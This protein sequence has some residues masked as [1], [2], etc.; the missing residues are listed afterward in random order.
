MSVLALQIRKRN[1]VQMG[2]SPVDAISKVIDRKSVWP[3]DVILPREDSCKV[4][5]IHAHFGDVRLQ[6]PRGKVQVTDSRVHNDRSRIHH[7]T[8][9][10]LPSRS[11]QFGHVQILRVSVQPVQLPAHPIDG[12]SLKAM[13]IVADYRLPLYRRLLIVHA[14][15]GSEDRLG[16]YVTEVQIIL[17]RVK[18]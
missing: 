12:N 5:A 8:A 9:Q 11:I 14:V 4:R 3:R 16:R 2:I 15:L 18:V 10:R 13:R 7:A 6:M 17:L 1:V